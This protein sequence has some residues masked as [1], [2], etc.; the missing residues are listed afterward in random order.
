MKRT[1][2]MLFFYV[3]EL[4][5]CGSR[6]LVFVLVPHTSCSGIPGVLLCFHGVSVISTQDDSRS[7]LF[8]QFFCNGIPVLSFMAMKQF[9]SVND[10]IDDPS[11]GGA[12]RSD[13]YGRITSSRV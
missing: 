3:N 4:L 8:I 10:S 2:F 13:L 7:F 6:R 1:S 12:S 9:K 5:T 11:S